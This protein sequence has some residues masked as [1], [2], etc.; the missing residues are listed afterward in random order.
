MFVYLIISNV[1]QGHW[2]GRKRDT[3]V[4]A[5]PQYSRGFPCHRSRRGGMGWCYNS[6]MAFGAEERCG[7]RR[8]RKVVGVNESALSGGE[9]EKSMRIYHGD[10][11]FHCGGWR[12]ERCDW[13]CL[14]VFERWC[15]VIKILI[16][17]L[18]SLQVGTLQAKNMIISSLLLLNI[19]FY[20]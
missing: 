11:G 16:H 4:V 8:W 7:C 19:D 6:P 14:I 13:F 17:C 1:K 20:I 10:V 5:W 18:F 9:K 3:A 15:F 2:T 12:R